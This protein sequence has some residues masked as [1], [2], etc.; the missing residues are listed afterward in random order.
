MDDYKIL[1]LLET[2]GANYGI[3]KEAIINKYKKWK[4][5]YKAKM[6]GVF[7]D[8]IELQFNFKFNKKS[9]EKLAKEIYKFCPD[10]IE[11]GFESI[12]RMSEY[13]LENS[14]IFLWWD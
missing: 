13:I 11:L 6:T 5:F 4:K 3:Y 8:W 14:K 9:A 1:R 2:N 10:S 7:L 12:D